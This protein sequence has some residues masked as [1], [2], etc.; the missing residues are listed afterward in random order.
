MLVTADGDFAST[1]K[2]LYDN[3]ALEFVFAPCPPVA[4]FPSGKRYNP[5]SYLIRKLRVPT[6][7]LNVYEDYIKK[8]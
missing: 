8:I 3:N 2:F 5:M 1:V 7:Y 4:Y 6:E